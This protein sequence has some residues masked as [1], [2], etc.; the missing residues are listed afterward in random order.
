MRTIAEERHQKTDQL[1]YALPLK[2]SDVVLGKYLALLTVIAI[3]TLII[4]I[5]P[6]ILS[7]YGSVSMLI[8]PTC[9]RPRM[10]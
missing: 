2:M 7:R 1:L 9:S 8:K 6:F 10:S 4:G 5:Y 3:P